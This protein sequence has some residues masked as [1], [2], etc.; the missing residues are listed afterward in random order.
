M[1]DEHINKII[2]N[3]LTIN[4]FH[5]VIFCAMDDEI[6][7]LKEKYNTYKNV[8]VFDKEYKFKDVADLMQN[9]HGGD[10]YA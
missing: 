3:A 9:L 8:I 4:T 7:K 5:L 2:E 10:G 1:G 6:K